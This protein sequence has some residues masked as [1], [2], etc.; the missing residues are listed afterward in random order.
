VRQILPDDGAV[1][2]VGVGS[3]VGVA[4]GVGVEVATAT[5][6]EGKGEVGRQGDA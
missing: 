4:W 5:T 3:A 1:V 6:V 2:A